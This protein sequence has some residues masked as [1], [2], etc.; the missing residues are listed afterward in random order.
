ML[1][2]IIIPLLTTVAGK[3]LGDLFWPAGPSR[4][5][6]PEAAPAGAPSFAQALAAESAGRPATRGAAPPPA[7]TAPAAP[8]VAGTF[9]PDREIRAIGRRPWV[10]G[11]LGHDRGDPASRV[12][13]V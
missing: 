11:A 10:P 5:A 8:A 6:R 4:P 13:A 3:V 1:A 2:G 12:E 7:A 9:A